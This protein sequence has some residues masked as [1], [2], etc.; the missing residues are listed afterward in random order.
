VAKQKEKVRLTKEQETLLITLYS[1][2]M[3]CPKSFFDDETSWDTLVRIDYD[4]QQ[5]KVPLKTSVTVCL[6]AKKLDDYVREFLV[7]SPKGIVLHLGSGLDSRF[8]RVDNGEVSWYDL[9]FPGVIDLRKK[10]FEE[11][12]RYHMISSS[13]M[14]LSW[15]DKIPQS[16]QSVCVVAEG[17]MMYLKENEVKAL[18]LKLKERFPGA[19]LVFDAFSKLTASKVKAHPSLR[20]TGAAIHWGI[21]DPQEIEGW[22]AGIKLQE[23]WFFNQSAEI[24]KLTFGYRLM[25]KLAGLFQVARKAQRIL[26]YRL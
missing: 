4:F 21:D 2:T 7:S 23:E 19:C 20:K 17:L 24:A 3:G 9:D 25:F 26:Y 6:R 14:D 15:L 5:L 8:N 16:T 1:K 12:D 18:V 13:V 11:S 10:L 22:A